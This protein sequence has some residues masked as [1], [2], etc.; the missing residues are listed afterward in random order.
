[1]DKLYTPH[2]VAE[3]LNVSPITVYRWVKAKKIKSVRF[4][5]QIRIPQSAVD[6]FLA[7]Q[8]PEQQSDVIEG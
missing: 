7:V 5:V 6:E 8:L 3:Y 2:E 1:M 4:G